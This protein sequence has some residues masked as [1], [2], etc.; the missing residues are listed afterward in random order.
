MPS[1][2][3]LDQTKIK[4]LSVMNPIPK[5]ALNAQSRRAVVATAAERMI[6][7]VVSK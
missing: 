6:L 2:S 5:Q 3:D 7:I 4:L 1:F